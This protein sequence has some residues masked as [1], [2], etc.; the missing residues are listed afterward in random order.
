MS[1]PKRGLFGFRPTYSGWSMDCP[2]VKLRCTNSCSEL[3]TCS[4][5]TF[6]NKSPHLVLDTRLDPRIF[7][8]TTKKSDVICGPWTFHRKGFYKGTPP[9]IQAHIAFYNTLFCF[10]KNNGKF[11]IKNN[12]ND[13]YLQIF[14]MRIQYCPECWVI[15]CG[16]HNGSIM[17]WLVPDVPSSSIPSK[18]S[19]QFYVFYL[20]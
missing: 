3:D 6:W 7:I 4:T 1:K 11:V 17:G 19:C 10:F 13:V 9:N 18:P 12:F 16:P 2:Q 15:F 20:G 8:L 5:G 14:R